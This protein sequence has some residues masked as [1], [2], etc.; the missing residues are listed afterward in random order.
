MH[1]VFAVSVVGSFGL[2][3]LF[4]DPLEGYVWWAGVVVFF[5]LITYV[6]VNLA[7]LIYFRRFARDQFNWF[8]HLV[9]PICGLALD[10]YLI[11]K[12]FFEAL[13]SGTFRDGKSIVL[14]GMM[15]AVLAAI[16]VVW[17]RLIGSSRLAGQAPV[18]EGGEPH[19]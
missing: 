17:L 4:D 16:Y 13:W 5:A 14:L 10:G 8:L 7:S 1:V 6:A 12:S 15:L 18:V 2:A 11:Y 9:I 19:R 3:F